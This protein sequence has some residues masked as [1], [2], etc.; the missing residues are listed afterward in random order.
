MFSQSVIPSVF[1]NEA[2]IPASAG[3]NPLELPLRWS[4]Q[5]LQNLRIIIQKNALAAAIS[6]SEVNHT[7]PISY[8]KKGWGPHPC[9]Y[10]LKTAT[11]SDHLR[12]TK[13]QTLKR[14]GI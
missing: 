4:A 13:A 1:S 3:T 12:A 2:S 9:F 14:S 5:M 7:G 10:W 8:T 6:F 11:A